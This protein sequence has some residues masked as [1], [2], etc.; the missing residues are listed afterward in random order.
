MNDLINLDATELA[1]LIRGR[2]VSSV[3][4]VSASIERIERINPLINAVVTPLFEDARRCAAAADRAIARGEP[5][6]LLHGV[7]VL[8]KDLFDFKAGVRNT[9]GCAA[10][11]D[12]V[13]SQ[14]V[15]HVERL[16]AAGAIIVG[17]TNT[18]E[19][20]HKGVTDNRLFGPTSTPFD[21][22]RNA[23][24][25]SGGSAAA[26]AAGMVALAQGS[27]AGGSVRIPAAWCGVVGFK[28]T[29]GRVPITGGGNAF[30]A[31]TPFVHVGPL[32]RTIRDAALMTDVL[33]GPDGRDPLSLPPLGA[34]LAS[35][36]LQPI[37]K[38]KVAFSPDWGVF[39]VQPEIA[40]TA[41]SAA[42]ALCEAGAEVQH[43]DIRLP[44]SQGE[45]AALWR[46][47]IG[48]LYAD[49]F[50]SFRAAGMDF[51]SDAGDDVP[52]AVR[53][54]AHYGS[55]ALALEAKKDDRL[56]TTILQT[57]EEVFA[58]FD[59]LMSPTLSCPPPI[60][61]TD[62]NTL[63]PAEVAGRAVERCIGWCLT[64]LVN[65]TGHPAASAPS[66][67]LDGLPTGVQIIGRRFAD[68]QVL[69]AGR[70]LEQVRPWEADLQ[71]V[72][73]SLDAG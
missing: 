3:E 56:R 64:H 13:P 21:L 72:W 73:K 6:G 58:E 46:R 9:F 33:S 68:G 44:C 26:V 59:L 30:G 32:S 66:G 27:D 20:G 53:E 65:F 36:C 2:K 57:L 43:V 11:A 62:G 39:A 49:M 14:S 8:I 42:F 18:P 48:I 37:E 19:F 15:A 29:F 71:R 31:H 50:D 4:V 52:D 28:P 60:N 5:I 23:G 51:L 45:L 63:G 17:K 69:A 16:E 38:L 1:E 54:A 22:S 67:L 24:G 61:G 35:A 70:A 41:R 40:E 55:A 34:N 47:Q 12:F 25:S 10:S 7:P